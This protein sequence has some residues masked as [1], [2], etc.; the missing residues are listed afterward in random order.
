MPLNLVVIGYMGS[1]KTAVGK[2]LAQFLG[3]SFYDLDSLII[4]IEAKSIN[5]IFI[6][7]G[8]K[9]F[10]LIEH[11]ILKNFL[12]QEMKSYILS[13]GGGTPCYH[14]NIMM[15]NNYAKTF[16]LKACPNT[17][18]QRLKYE[19]CNRP[20]IHKVAD[21][22]LLDFI[23]IHLSKRTP[24]YEQAHEHI[25]IYNKSIKTIVQE[26]IELC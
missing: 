3:I 26:I 6:K 22:N 23:S 2:L 8:E 5:E 12:K 1:G 13:V 21:T 18:F 9:N 17:L 7:K 11:D 15:M 19:K 10:R 25:N 20:I 14:N 24:F 16:Y 4:K